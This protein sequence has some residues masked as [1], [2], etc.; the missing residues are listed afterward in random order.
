VT[1]ILVG[2]QP[3]DDAATLKLATNDFM[4]RG[5]DG[6]DVLVDQP[7]IIDANAGSLMAGQV[8][9]YIEEAGTIAPTVEGRITR[10]D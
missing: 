6:Y 4:G 2:G 5:G 7:R 3:L 10:L 1:E 9:D 8:I